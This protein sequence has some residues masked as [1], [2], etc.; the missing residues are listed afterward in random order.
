M[1]RSVRAGLRGL[2]LR[3]ER[4]Q[5]RPFLELLE[6]VLSWKAEVPDLWVGVHDRVHLALVAGA[7]G[8]HLG[9]RSLDARRVRD[10]VGEMTLGCSTHAGDDPRLGEICDYVFHGPV[11][12][13]P[14]KRGWKEPVGLEGLRQAVLDWDVPV[15][16]IGGIDP[17]R[18]RAVLDAG[19]A[20]VAA[21]RGILGQDHPAREVQAYLAQLEPRP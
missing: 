16:G 11:F 1:R 15:L 21:L 5:D 12:D 8:V 9:F 6:E 13:T 17:G 18:A 10:L 19:A 7:D 4:L 14:S 3:E 2:L 20:G